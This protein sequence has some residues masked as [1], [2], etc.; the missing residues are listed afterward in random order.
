MKNTM[1]CLVIA[2]VAV[3]GFSF[4]A[5]GD[6]G[7][8]G[9]SNSATYTGYDDGGKEYKL[10][11]SKGANNP[12]TG[13]GGGGGGGGNSSLNGRWVADYGD[14]WVFNNGNLT[15]SSLGE[16]FVK[17]TYTTSGSNITI[18]F[19]QIKGWLLYG[20]PSDIG[21]SSDQ[22]YTKSQFRTAVINYIVTE[23]NLSQ[24]DAVALVDD[25]EY[26]ALFFMYEPSTS[27]YSLSGN[28]LTITEG[29][30]EV[31]N[32]TKQ[33]GISAFAVSLSSSA[34]RAAYSPQSGDNYK[35]TI[36][37]ISVSTGTVISVSG[38]TLTLKHKD[39]DEFTVTVSGNNITGFNPEIPL[40]SGGTLPA[41][42][43]LSPNKPGGGGGGGGSGSM[44]WTAVANST[45]GTQSSIDAIAYGNNKFVAVGSNIADGGKIAYSTNGA[46]WTAVTDSK[47]GSNSIS[48]IA[49]GGGR[50]VAVGRVGETAYSTDGISWTA[51]S[52][53]LG[54]NLY[55]VA[56][57]GNKFVIGGNFGKMAYSTDGTSWT[58]VADSGIWD[59]GGGYNK[60]HIQAIAYG[61]G[62]FVAAGDDARMAYSTDG[63]SWTQVDD[64]KLDSGGGGKS[65]INTVVYGGNRWVAGNNDGKMAYS[66]DGVNWTAVAD[67]GFGLS[68]GSWANIYG[69]AWGNSRFVAVGNVGVM[70]YSSDGISWT[71]VAEADNK[72][73]FLDSSI[74]GIAYGGGRFVAVGQ[75]GIGTNTTGKIAYANW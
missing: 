10:V 1:R 5:C 16:E 59:R 63:I 62:K 49:Y 45:F 28:T 73:K 26:E 69:I 58:A 32:F 25:E 53:T 30:G 4:T 57:G 29:D 21:L 48:A 7:D 2:L 13:G 47:F 15:L 31:L 12:G 51:V 38:S 72:F 14:I 27:Q 33:G 34:D 22:W 17:G 50:F 18:T 60:I 66:T 75:E 61:G 39:G 37:G 8:G 6:G 11:I 65:T 54:E 71:T 43:S 42:E 9:D 20:E 64:S 40:D 3:I 41:P 35:L 24:A 68:T 46:S 55:A 23:Y 74:R 67:S 44:T 36:G 19:T 56:Y 52:S 70:A